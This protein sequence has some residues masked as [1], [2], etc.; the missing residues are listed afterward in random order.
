MIAGCGSSSSDSAATTTADPTTD[1]L[2]QVLARGTLVLSTDLK[3]PPQSMGV[4][5]AKRRA[6]TKCAANQLTAPEVDGYD[7]ETGKLVAQKLGVEPCFVTP[8]WSEITGGNWGDR[9]DASWGSGAINSDRMTR[10]YMTQPYYSDNQIFYVK[11]D[12]PITDPRTLSGK[13]VGACAGCTHELYL[14]HTLEVPGVKI[15]FFLDHP[16]IVLYDVEGPGLAAVAKGKLVAFICADPVGRNAIKE[17]VAIRALSPSPFLSTPRASSTRAPDCR[18]PPSWRRPMRSLRAF[19]PTAPWQ[20]SRRNG[21]VMQ[22]MRATPQTSI[23]RPWDKRRNDASRKRS[24][25]RLVARN[26]SGRSR[27]RSLMARLVLTFLALSLLMVGIVGAVSYQRAR[28]SL[29]AQVFDRLDAAEE[30]KADSLDR[31]IDE[32]RRNVVFVGGL[33]GGFHSGDSSGLGKAAQQVL[34]S[35]N[36]A[37]RGTPAHKTIESALEYVVSQTADAQEFLVLD[38]DGKVVVSTVPDHEGRSLSKEPWFARGSSGTFVQ[39][40][41]TPA[42]TGKPDDH[43]RDAALRP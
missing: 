16:K 33:L 27:R 18:R 10:L 34:Q 4:K 15:A 41:S 31:W 29:E 7:V 21:S 32:Q 8:T 12:S 39:P 3:Y 24:R 9:W 20:H 40:V 2:A 28:S 35:G 30:L 36:T 26:E 19:M 25:S 5:G 22:N 14:K 6:N 23:W 37:V 1:K 17:G 42:L 38:L 43:D 11:K 13:S